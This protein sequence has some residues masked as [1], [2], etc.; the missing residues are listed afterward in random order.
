MS[1]TVR[2]VLACAV[3]A[4][5]ALTI[6][7][8]LLVPGNIL[9]ASDANIGW[10]NQMKSV[11]PKG[12]SG[13]WLAAGLLGGGTVAP[14]SSGNVLLCGLPVS[15]YNNWVYAIHLGCASFFLL[16][17]L[18]RFGVGWLGALTGVVAAF[19]IGSNLTL[20]Y[21]GHIG[22]FEVLLFA[23]AGLWLLEKSV[24]SASWEWSA[25]AGVAMGAM[26]PDQP[27]LALLFGLALGTHALVRCLFLYRLRWA[28]ILKVLVPAGVTALLIAGPGLLGAYMVSADQGKPVESG[29]QGG[30]GGWEF[31]TQW[32]F[33]P[34]ESVD[35]IAP[36]Y[37]GWRSGEPD[38][39]YWGRT[40]RSAGWEQTRKGFMNLRLESPY[41]G[42]I[43]VLLAILALVGALAERRRN[44]QS[45]QATDARLY[46]SEWRTLVLIW[47]AVA[48]IS[49][50]LSFGKYFPLYVLFYKLPAMGSMRNPNKFLQVFQFA[51]GILAACGFHRA[52]QMRATC[53][54]SRSPLWS[55]V[56]LGVA[57]AAFALLAMSA[58][59]TGDGRLTQ[60]SEL[61]SAGWGSYAAAIV[62]NKIRALWHAALMCVAAA[63]ALWMLLGKRLDAR[64]AFRKAAAVGLVALVMADA[65]LLSRHYVQA[66]PRNSIVGSNAVIELLRSQPSHE[67]VLMFD[68]SGV[69][70]HWLSIV[71]PYYQLVPFNIVQMPRMPADY[72]AFLGALGPNPLRLWQIAS[73]RY[74]LCPAPLWHKI[75]QDPGMKAC[76]EPV[77]GFDLV[78]AA[79]GV[80]VRP[81]V[82][83][84]SA[85][86]WVLR[87]TKGR[88]RYSLVTDWV[89]LP[90]ESALQQIA[91]PEFDA[92]SRA[93]VSGPCSLT[94]SPQ[95][96]E[97]ASV[98][99]E[100]VAEDQRATVLKTKAS[101]PAVL[102]ISQRFES[103][104]SAS[105]DGAPVTIMRCDYAGMGIALGPGEHKVVLQYRP[106]LRGLWIQA[107]GAVVAL[108]AVVSLLL[109]LF[110]KSPATVKLSEKPG[111]A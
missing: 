56:L 2:R 34:D 1:S 96:S 104:W 22:K 60:V 36:G 57:F 45:V 71:F 11:F 101:V 80:D 105:V 63:V 81:A 59:A 30:D 77:M 23:S 58:V 70:N 74:A 28:P 47:G 27:D 14:L 9:F 17:F 44:P 87:F 43:P 64:P 88:A 67:R 6:Y 62:D 85:Q 5:L 89:V 61:S 7:R 95:K 42:V 76:F 84:E 3:V 25:L 32:S 92:L 65:V 55:R 109:R 108:A 15:V 51:V 82:S 24:R 93:V 107:G 50:L 111:S 72:Q 4:G 100:I 41:I 49:L 79:G 73:V 26:F 91:A 75:Q 97:S 66:S 90:D 99:V 20:A 78:P 18:R 94:P 31:S 52:V 103:A 53:D 29:Q 33:P 86:H 106:P 46:E 16:S 10:L 40:G 38:G 35:L 8:D 48:A 98:P 102:A 54:G 39:P 68:Q 37:T 110:V 19:W 83:A 69:F 21:A 12:F 13:Y